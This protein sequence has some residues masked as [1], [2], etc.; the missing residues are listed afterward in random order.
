MRQL[1]KLIMIEQTIRQL[2]ETAL[3][4]AKGTAVNAKTTNANHGAGSKVIN[5]RW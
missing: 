1:K 5:L 4:T 3:L 2:L